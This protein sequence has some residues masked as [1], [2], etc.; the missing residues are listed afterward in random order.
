M[1]DTD[2]VGCN[3]IELPAGSYYTRD[4]LRDGDVPGK[5]SRCQIEVDVAWDKFISH[6][7]EGDWDD[8]APLRVLSFDIECAGRK[9][10]RVSM[11]TTLNQYK[12]LFYLC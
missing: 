10:C 6:K 4:E 3:W 9:V 1:V 12:T 11:K 7:P 8:I 2:V 5:T